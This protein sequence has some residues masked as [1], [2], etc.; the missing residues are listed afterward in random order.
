VC[1][2]GLWNGLTSLHFLNFSLWISKDIQNIVSGVEEIKL[3]LW[4]S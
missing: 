4:V 1:E 3:A 2:R